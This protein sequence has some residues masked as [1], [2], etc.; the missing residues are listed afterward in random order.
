MGKV[1]RG[2]LRAFHTSPTPS[3]SHTQAPLNNSLNSS[4]IRNTLFSIRCPLQRQEET[5][6][7]RIEID[8][9][10][11]EDHLRTDPDELQVPKISSLS[12]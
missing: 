8:N 10:G 3:P 1:F 7:T 4:G 11:G 2:V 5:C 9:H 12:T 6:R